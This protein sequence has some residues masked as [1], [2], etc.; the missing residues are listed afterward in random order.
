[1]KISTNDALYQKKKNLIDFNA[2]SVASEGESIAHAG[3]RL[4]DLVK[5]IASGKKTRT[6]ENGFR[7]ISIF[8]DGVVL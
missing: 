4:F 3:R 5:E 1:M 6:E 8:K 7:E 2:G